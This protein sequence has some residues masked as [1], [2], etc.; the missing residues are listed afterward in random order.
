ML[1]CMRTTVRLPEPLLE[2]AKR[3]AS[4]AGTTLTAVLEDALLEYLSRRKHQKQH[5]TPVRL[6]TFGGRGVRKGIDLDDSASLLDTLEEK[7]AAFRR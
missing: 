7:D 6:P 4:E 2:D 1:R 3:A 5:S